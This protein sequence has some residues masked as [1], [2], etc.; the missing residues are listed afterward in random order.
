MKILFL[1]VLILLTVNPN[2]DKIS[3]LEAVSKILEN[4]ETDF[5]SVECFLS[6][7]CNAT[8]LRLM[9]SFIYRK[10]VLLWDHI[11]PVLIV[12]FLCIGLT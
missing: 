6:Y 3:G 1:L 11:C 8:T 9:R 12:A 7:F 10:I 2:I 5:T 4:K